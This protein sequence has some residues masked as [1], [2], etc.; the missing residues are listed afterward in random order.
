MARKRKGELPSGSIRKQV[1]DHFE[2]LFDEAGQPIIDPKTGKQKKKRI[3]TSITRSSVEE[4]NIAKAEAKLNKASKKQPANMTLRE[5]IQKYISSSDAVLSPTT[6]R[7]YNTILNNGFIFIMDMKLSKLSTEILKEAVNQEAKRMTK[8]KKPH[9]ISSKTVS[10]EY[11]L[12]AAVLNIYAPSLDTSVKLPARNPKKHE[13]SPP[14][15]IFN[16][17]KGTEIELPVLLA[18]WLSFSI[19]EIKGLYKSKS[20]SSNGNFI[21]V[22][23]VTVKVGK[24]E[25]TKDDAKQIT[26]H[27]T[28]RIPSYIKDLIAN[29]ETDQLVT[30]S[31]SA[32]SN[33]FKR[34]ILKNKIPYMTFHDLRHVNASVMNLLNIPDKYAQE[35]GGWK[36]D[37]VMKGTY[38][39]TFTR[40]R[41]EVDDTIDNYFESLLFGTSETIDKKYNAWLFLLDL[42]DTSE[43]K[44]LYESFMAQKERIIL[45]LSEAEFPKVQHEMQHEKKNP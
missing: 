14:D 25:I 1:F 34:L 8:G 5:A 21:S 39:Q 36:T 27:R 22:V 2:P 9:R 20:I 18:M 3:Y 23:Q 40:A 42:E 13:I 33:R 12:I 44:I 32:V 17:V 29:V 37:A 31:A 38:M 26:R 45:L 16:I 15:V 35:R 30:L 7:G 24:K 6:A 11:G 19:S 10:N 4:V 43:N 28:H 41:V